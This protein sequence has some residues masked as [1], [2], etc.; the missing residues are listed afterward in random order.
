MSIETLNWGINLWDQTHNILKFQDTGFA[1]H[2]RL[3]DFLT[4][5]A[6]LQSDAF[7]NQKK[8]CE[9]YL[10]DIK[11]SVGLDNTYATTFN[12]FVNNF[13]K[14]VDTENLIADSFEFQANTD[15]RMNLDDHKKRIKRWKQDRD[16]FNNEMKSQTR[17]MEDEMRR[18][19]DKYRDMLRAKEDYS[20]TELDQ[21]TS[22]LEVEKAHNFY[23][24]KQKDFERARDDFAMAL[25]QFNMYRRSF[26]SYTLPNWGSV[27]Y[28]INEDRVEKTQ[29]LIDNICQRFQVFIERLQVVHG[30]LQSVSSLPDCQ[31]DTQLLV[32]FLRTG[33]QPPPDLPFRDITQA[34]SDHTSLAEGASLASGRSSN[35]Q[36][37]LK[38]DHIVPKTVA[39]FDRQIQRINCPPG[40]DEPTY[41]TGPSLGQ[42]IYAN[43]DEIPT[44]GSVYMALSN[45]GDKAVR[46]F[47]LGSTV[48]PSLMP[49]PPGHHSGSNFIRKLFK[50]R[51]HVS[52]CGLA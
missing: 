18:Y 24:V 48:G 37:G 38:L 50:G 26:F 8:L 36:D 41:A 46:K 22:R 47:S 12:Q 35:A 45:L 42:G 33:R 52:F 3:F 40:L 15:L 21:G 23:Q 43:P 30:E 11:K 27:G 19:K 5:F 1:L 7:L 51:S 2:E 9:K 32:E 34:F 39:N 16:R 28:Q 44:Y 10:I 14:L 13:R 17:I 6:K 20:K 49:P 31:K 29:V 25:E 4:A